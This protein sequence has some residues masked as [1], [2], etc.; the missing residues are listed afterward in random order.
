[1]N[2]NTVITISRQYGSGGRELSNILAKKLGIKLY[3]RQI[4]NLA[5]EQ[6]GIKDMYFDK[7]K[8]L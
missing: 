1:M 4:I 5:A 8:I 7:M 6:L 3:D 2:N